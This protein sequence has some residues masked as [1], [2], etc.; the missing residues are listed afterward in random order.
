MALRYLDLIGGHKPPYCGKKCAFRK[1][2][3]NLLFLFLLNIWLENKRIKAFKT[4]LFC[5]CGRFYMPPDAF[6][7][8]GG[9]G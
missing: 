4:N 1:V 8:H 5:S 6:I 7:L 2:F 3:L 9:G